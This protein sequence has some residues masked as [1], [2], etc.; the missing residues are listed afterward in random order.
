MTIRKLLALSTQCAAVVLGRSARSRHTWLR[1]RLARINLPLQSVLHR[2]RRRLVLCGE[3]DF[4]Q[5]VR[6]VLGRFRCDVVALVQGLSNRLRSDE[7]LALKRAA[8]V[9]CEA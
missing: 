1:Q 8:V 7:L 2:V 3:A 6:C 5:H 4:E 9:A